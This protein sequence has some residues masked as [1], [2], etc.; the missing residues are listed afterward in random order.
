MCVL[1]AIGFWAQ[2]LQFYIFWKL[3]NKNCN[4][5]SCVV[6][7]KKKIALL[8]HPLPVC[9][10]GQARNVR[11]KNLNLSLIFSSYNGLLNHFFVL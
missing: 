4:Y 6:K 2:S 1:F 7:K 10:M 5:L 3:V 8:L 9:S 11:L